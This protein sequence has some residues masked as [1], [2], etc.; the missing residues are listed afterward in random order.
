[1]SSPSKLDCS[2]GDWT[3]IFV[4]QDS[5]Q[6]PQQRK[7]PWFSETAP[8]KSPQNEEAQARWFS[9]S[10]S[11]PSQKHNKNTLA[12]ASDGQA[13]EQTRATRSL[14]VSVPN[15]HSGARERGGSEAVHASA[16]RTRQQLSPFDTK[17]NNLEHYVSPHSAVAHG[18]CGHGCK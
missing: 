15:T 17:K 9:T 7:S 1:M 10:L 18:L 13:R 2:G 16:S 8:I 4:G 11:T 12:P 14:S 3:H 6:P 5:P